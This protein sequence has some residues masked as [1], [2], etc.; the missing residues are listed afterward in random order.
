MF[1]EVR[2]RYSLVTERVPRLPLTNPRWRM[3]GGHLEFRNM[4]ISSYCK[5]F[6]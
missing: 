4:L 6:A 5:I 2:A 1:A 3:A